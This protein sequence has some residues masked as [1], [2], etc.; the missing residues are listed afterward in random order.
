MKCVFSP[1]SFVILPL[2]WFFSHSFSPNSTLSVR[3]YVYIY[4]SSIGYSPGASVRFARPTKFYWMSGI[5]ATPEWRSSVQIVTSAF[6]ECDGY[7]EHQP[8]IES[9]ER[10]GAEKSPPETPQQIEE[11]R[12]PSHSQTRALQRVKVKSIHLAN[13]LIGGIEN[14]RS[15]SIGIGEFS[16]DPKASASLFF[17]G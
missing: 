6:R 4:I 12:Q 16:L 2:F 3:L 11:E 13:R 17:W 10:R 8:K 15:V 9:P 5:C 7:G 14:S 1:F